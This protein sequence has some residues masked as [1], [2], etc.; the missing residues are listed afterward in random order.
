MLSL[1]FG[2]A[3]VLSLYIERPLT[4]EQVRQFAKELGCKE[5]NELVLG[6]YYL[7][8]RLP[9]RT[10]F[11]CNDVMVNEFHMRFLFARKH[12]DEWKPIINELR[13]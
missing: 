8:A 4:A 1:A 2:M 3:L 10:I 7:G 9:D 5:K 12:E 11:E 6:N 13:R